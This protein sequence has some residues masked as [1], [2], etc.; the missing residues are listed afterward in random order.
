MSQNKKPNTCVIYCRV[1]SKKQAQEGDSL[2]KQ[3]EICR[4]YMNRNN[5]TLQREVFKE[6]YTGRADSRPK[7]DEMMGYLYTNKNKIGYVIVRSIDRFTRGGEISYQKIVQKIRE[8]GIE[9]KDTEGVI[10]DEIDLMPEYNGLAD[11]YSFSKKRPSQISENVVAQAKQDMVNDQLRRLIGREIDL[12]Q[13]GYW[14]GTFPFGFST[15]KEKDTVSGTKKKTILIPDTEEAPFIRHI[16]QLRA[17]GILT[18]KQIVE[19]INKDGYKSRI[20]TK[21]DKDGVRAI[22]TSGG[23]KLT[24]A[25]LQSYIRMPIFAGIMRK[26]W[27]HYLPIK[28]QFDGL[29]S[30]EIWNKAN[31]GKFYIKALENNEYQWIEDFDE[32]KRVRT[33]VS[34]KYPYKFVI[35]CPLCGK[36]FWASA[37][38]GKSGKKFPSYHCSGVIKKKATHTHYGV[39]ADEFNETVENFIKKLKFTKKYYVA[40]EMVMKDIYFKKHEEQ[41]KTSKDIAHIIQDKRTEVQTLHQ[42]HR[43]ATSEIIERK[44]E[45]EIENLDEEITLLEKDRNNSETTEHDFITYLKHAKYLLEHPGE[46]L[47]K[48]RAKEEQQAIWSLVFRELP[49]YEEIK[50]GTPKLSLCFNV[51][52]TNEG[53]S[54]D[55][56]GDEGFEPPT[57]AV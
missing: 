28:A 46:I 25:Q 32:K 53:G 56:V 50:T 51:K 9:V 34:E 2:D 11:E 55:V 47:L 35:K 52:T 38:R 10:Q 27:T 6:A 44:I 45:E 31:K 37:S 33:K 57:F 23:N 24:V 43:R 49:T 13:A 21:W 17:E 48:P 5:L 8:L 22:G 30:I 42:K 39:S 14:I 40:F 26:K 15:K 19:K 36:N 41:I 18:D 54:H 20:R 4:S 16:F 1:S 7:L 12:T 29:V 3:E